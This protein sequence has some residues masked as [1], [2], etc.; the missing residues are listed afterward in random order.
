MQK[1]TE[2]NKK[3]VSVIVPVYNTKV[4]FIKECLDSIV[5]Q[6]LEKEDI[7]II[8]VDDCSPDKETLDFVKKLSLKK[9]YK[10]VDLKV[11]FHEKNK[12]VAE[13]RN[14]GVKEAVGKYVVCLDSDD[15]IKKDYLK[16]A[17][18]LLETSPDAGFVYP[19]V[20]KFGYQNATTI[21]EDF[22]TFRIFYRNFCPNASM[23][24]K[25]VWLSVKQRESFVKDKIQCYIRCFEDWDFFTRLIGKGWYGL[26]LRDSEFI[27]RQHILS[28]VVRGIKMHGLSMYFNVI[29][30][31]KS[32]LSL[33]KVYLAYRKYK[34]TKYGRHRDPWDPTNYPDKISAILSN[35]AISKSFGDGF[36][37]RYLP[38][39]ILINSLF[40]PRKFINEIISAK[41]TMTLA[42]IKSGF[43][44]KPIYDFSFPVKPR[45]N[46]IKSVMFVNPWWRVGGA[47]KVLLDWIKS[48]REIHG[49]K[50]TN[51]VEYSWDVDG[52]MKEDFKKYCDELYSLDKIGQNPLIKLKFCWNLIAKE[53]PD[54]LFIAYNSFFYILSP[55][56][57]KYLPKIKII[58]LIHTEDPVGFSWFEIAEE[59]KN[60]LDKR[61]VI[62]E[63]W[64]EVH[65]KRYKTP[66]EKINIFYNSIDLKKFD[67]KRYNKKKLKKDFKIDTKKITLG[68]IG[69]VNYEK[70]P[71]V[72]LN[73]ADLMKENT[74]YNF[75]MVGE[76]MMLE[77]IKKKA[78]TIQNLKY[79]G[80]TK[81]SSKYIAMCDVLICPSK[82]EGYPLIGIEAAAMNVPIIATNVTGFKEQIELGKFGILYDQTGDNEKDARKIKEIL[83]TNI[84]KLQKLG[85]NGRAFAKKYHDFEKNKLKYR[86][87]IESLLKE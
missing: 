49:L 36:V 13:A 71:E 35:K 68:F 37:I 77:E 52:K 34:N 55:L 64:K 83:L 4:E 26:P 25:Q 48:A 82:F 30:N 72:F 59:Y 16:K 33:F 65:N 54:I 18:L 6:T 29:N 22:S 74:E 11:I 69:R 40:F 28:G 23:T 24:R 9:D 84:K 56:I 75:I 60:S 66:E 10:G 15:M 86:R 1:E 85:K 2:E 76:G 8:V 47:E 78:K 45:E 42:E 32:F 80:S 39:K 58:D 53:Q 87:F 5:G 14:T 38:L 73:L 12:W 81:D 7:E 62:S 44:E 20:R 43:G 41:R 63:I 3:L 19:N 70:N 51:V 17:A 31:K 61:L 27:Y 21:A 50:I 57:K 46:K 67:S 79:L